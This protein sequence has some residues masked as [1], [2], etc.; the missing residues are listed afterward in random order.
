M[1]AFF[2]GNIRKKNVP[3]VEKKDFDLK[4]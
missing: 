4:K 3:T 1:G 2:P